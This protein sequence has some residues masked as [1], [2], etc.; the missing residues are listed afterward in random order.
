M[1]SAK[2]E[3]ARA[4]ALLKSGDLATAREIILRRLQTEPGDLQALVLRTNLANLDGDLDLLIS[5]LQELHRQLPLQG[6]F[7]SMLATALNNRASRRREQG[8]PRGA[9]ADLEQAI[10]LQPDHPH[11]WFNLGL[12]ARDLGLNDIAVQAFSR[13]LGIRPEDTVATLLR[14]T[15]QDGAAAEQAFEQQV[16][17]PLTGLDPGWLAH[18]AARAGQIP[19]ALQ[20]LQQF[21]AQHDH[22]AALEALSELRIRGEVEA[23]EQAAPSVIRAAQTAGRSFLRA[24]LIQQLALPAIYRDRTHLERSRSR[25]TDGLQ[26][27][28]QQ[29]TPDHIV[30][31]RPP[32]HQLAH[33]NFLLAYQGQDDTHL[34]RRYAIL[35][36]RAIAALKPAWLEAPDPLHRRRI[37]LLSSCWR[38][39][40]VGSYFSCWIRWLVEAGHEVILYQWGPL[41]DVLTDEF[42]AMASGYRFL[43]GGIETVAQQVREDRLQLLIYPELGMDARLLPLAAMRLAPRQAVGWGH[44]VSTGFSAIDVFLSCAS[45]EPEAGRQ[46]YHERVVGLPG[47]GVDYRRPPLPEPAQP[48]A[49]DLDPSR[50]RVLVPQSLFKLHPDGDQVMLQIA[51]GCPKVQFVLFAAERANWVATFRAR[52]QQTFAGEGLDFEHHLSMQPISSRERFLQVN[53]ACDLMLDSL[54]W[55]GGNT[56]LDALQCGLPLVTVPGRFMRG[57]QST[58]MLQTLGL[59]PELV[60]DTPEAQAERVLDLLESPAELRHIGGRIARSLDRLFDPSEARAAFLDWAEQESRA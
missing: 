39:C 37:G 41:R 31:G 32:L 9:H 51:R 44:P 19:A 11:A 53:Q 10:K 24:E 54:H 18:T 47:L 23:L 4:E 35:I 49:L 40:T 52:L 30:R 38:T 21:E 25:Y 45:M 58:A 26:A 3:L 34:Q 20:A 36:E 17:S 29:W 14:A 42:A 1:S 6:R 15:L 28:E 57:R 48:G 5:S 13:H 7:T 56:A 8:D 50:P 59:G 60:C 33:C 46:H 16:Q 12:C 2:A 22:G 55:S 27:L 43:Q